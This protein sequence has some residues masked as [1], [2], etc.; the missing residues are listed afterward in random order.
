MK[1]DTKTVLAVVGGL[2]LVGYAA[3]VAASSI[4]DNIDYE[5]GKP[6]LDSQTPPT[7][8]NGEVYARIQLP[9]SITNRNAVGLGIDSFSGVVSYGLIT[10]AQI[11]IPYQVWLAAGQTTIINID[12]NIPINVVMN[13]IAAAVSSGNIL[14]TIM[15][16]I[17]LNGEV[18]IGGLTIPIAQTAI[19][20]I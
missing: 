11:A 19:P 20:I 5:V 14:S 15:N 2:A 10:L 13:D 9:I 12:I 16:K 4:I 1:V 18:N 8:P 6:T 7:G 3:T 17:Y